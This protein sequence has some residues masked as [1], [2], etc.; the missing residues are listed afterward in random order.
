MTPRFKTAAA[1]VLLAGCT[2]LLV[3]SLNTTGY[4]NPRIPFEIQLLGPYIPLLLAVARVRTERVSRWLLGYV[5]IQTLFT[6]VVCYK[7]PRTLASG[8][9]D[10]VPY[11]ALAQI[12]VPLLVLAGV[13][14]YDRKIITAQHLLFGFLIVLNVSTLLLLEVFRSKLEDARQ[15]LLSARQGPAMREAEADFRVGRLRQYEVQTFPSAPGRL[16]P[17]ERTF[18]GRSNGPFEVWSRPRYVRSEDEAFRLK[19]EVEFVSMYNG[20]MAFLYS[21][22][23]RRTNTPP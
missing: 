1:L 19:L 22:A 16:P 9:E 6:F 17:L 18:T 2:S 3:S 23:Q 20:R 8:L 15:E 11:V 4:G 7:V 13:Q 14:W 5:S 10:R 12:A 21:M